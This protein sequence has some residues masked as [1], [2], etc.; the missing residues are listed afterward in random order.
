MSEGFNMWKEQYEQMRIQRDE[1]LKEVELA[2]TFL[3]SQLV[4]PISMSFN[5]WKAYLKQAAKK[6]AKP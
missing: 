4:N 6:E 5:E 3:T 1:A 2:C